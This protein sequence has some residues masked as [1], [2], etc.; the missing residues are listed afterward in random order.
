MSLAQDF[1]L[2]I[3]GS[4]SGLTLIDDQLNDWRIALIDKGAGSTGAFGGTCL[5]AGCI[6]TKMLSLPARYATMPLRSRQVDTTITFEGINHHDLVSRVFGRTDAISEAGLAGLEARPNVTVL[7]GDAVFVGDHQVKVASQVIS[8]PQIVLA[9]GSRPL[10]VTAPGFAEREL[11]AFVHTSESV[12]RLPEVPKRLVIVGAGVEAVEFGHIFSALGSKVSIIARGEALLRHGDP[13]ISRLITAEMSQRAALRF[14]QR[15]TNL[16]ANPD[17][18]VVVTAA[19]ALGIEYTY[20]ADV[21]LSAIGRVPNG[22]QLRLDRTGIILDEAGFVP[23]DEFMRT[24]VPG[25]WALGDICSPKMLK[26]LANAQARVVKKNLLAYRDSDMLTRSD[27]R[28][29]PAGIFGEPEIATVGA[30]VAQLEADGRNFVSYAHP[31][32]DVA[33]GWA[34]GENPGLVKVLVD[35]VNRRLLGAHI[36][37]EQATSLIQPL[38][39]AMQF[40]IDLARFA[41]GQYWIHPGLTEVVENAV[42]GALRLIREG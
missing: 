9:A 40:D 33:Y 39:M 8:A 2:I 18:G 19:D 6:P 20:E 41:R 17:G 22:D 7:R 32:N 4:G 30:T 38:V 27:E 42:L 16:E 29:V 26:H 36:I 23:V 34:M 14:N 5:N 11:R 12:M 3:I 37:G 35:P 24:P 15:V 31:F 13:D 25:I 21:V 28:F 10:P 1:D